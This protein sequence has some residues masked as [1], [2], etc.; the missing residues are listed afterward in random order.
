M[1][2]NGIRI[3]NH[4]L[5]DGSDREVLRQSN[6]TPSPVLSIFSCPRVVWERYLEN[7]TDPGDTIVAG[8]GW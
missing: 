1:T 3:G 5:T 7:L 6:L 8:W 4:S 2:A